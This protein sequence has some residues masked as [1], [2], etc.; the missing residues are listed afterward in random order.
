M[1][2][3]IPKILRK[4]MLEQLH[5]GHCGMVL[6]KEIAQSYFW[7]S[8]LD[9]DIEEK[10]RDCI[11]SPGVRNA[12]QLAPLHPW[13][14]PEKPWQ[15]IYVDFAGPFEG[16]MLLLKVDAH[17]KWPEVCIVPST[18]AES[19]IQKLQGI[20]CNFGLPEQLVSD[21]G[22]QFVSQ[23]FGY[24]MKANRIHQITS[25]PYHPATNGLAE[26]F[27]QTTKQALKSVRGHSFIQKS[28]DT[29]LLSYRNILHATT[30]VS[31]AFLMM[32]R[33]LHMCFDVLKPSEL[34]QIVQCQHQGQ[35][36]RRASRAK[37]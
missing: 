34:Q 4:Q 24:F 36:I 11:S 5:S 29:F 18:T 3:I 21:N 28:L 2:V 16:S 8:G 19:T 33:Q 14:W 37:D 10:A 12:P 20:F 1:R 9:S 7:W 6:M 30:K 35:V 13:D 31:P 23:E 17:S 15:R 25:A 22:L 27:V 26:R 32:G